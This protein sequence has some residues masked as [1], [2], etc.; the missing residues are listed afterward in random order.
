MTHV[1]GHLLDSIYFVFS[2]F[3]FQ[4]IGQCRMHARAADWNWNEYDE[5]IKWV[6]SENKIQ[7]R[8]PIFV[9]SNDTAIASWWPIDMPRAFFRD[10]SILLLPLG[11][12]G[13]RSGTWTL[14]SI[15]GSSA[16]VHSSRIS[17]ASFL[18]NRQQYSLLSNENCWNHSATFNERTN[19]E[20]KSPIY[21]LYLRLRC[22]YLFGVSFVFI[23]VLNNL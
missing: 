23:H 10:I 2:F 14:F 6:W 20:W 4:Q 18:C 17:I 16:G 22:S 13:M 21:G 9:Y 12:S 5:V 3:L 19:G 8:L 11:H 7:W 15:G 1:S